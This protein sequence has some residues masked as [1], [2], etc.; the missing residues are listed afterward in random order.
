M[1]YHEVRGNF[2]TMSDKLVRVKRAW[3]ES[4]IKDQEGIKQWL[5]CDTILR[6][7]GVLYFC[8]TIEEIEIIPEETLE[9]PIE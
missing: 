7:N 3:D 6:K 1:E 4:N 5:G 9:Q 8:K 2:I